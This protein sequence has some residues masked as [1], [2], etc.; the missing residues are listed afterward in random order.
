[1]KISDLKSYKVVSPSPLQS[2][3]N[4]VGSS[5]VSNSSVPPVSG[6]SGG[7]GGG[8]SVNRAATQG[9]TYGASFPATGR[10]TPGQ[11]G[12]K[13]LGNL[14]SSGLNLAK[15]AASFGKTVLGAVK[16]GSQSQNQLLNIF[17]APAAKAGQFLK[18]KAT[19][20]RTET[21]ATQTF[22]VM[23]SSLKERYGSVEN[24]KK[25]A[26]NDPAGFG[27]D[28]LA[29]I[30]GGAGLAG[31]SRM[32]GNAVSKVGGVV[33]KPVSKIASTGARVAEEIA[34][35]AAGVSTGVGK[36]AFKQALRGGEEFT[37]GLRGQMDL[38]TV[39]NEARGGLGKVKQLRSSEYGQA[40]DNLA[41]LN[42]QSLETTPILNKVKGLLKDFNIKQT[43]EGGL[44][45]SRSPLVN[46]KSKI[47]G[48]I[49]VIDE[50]GTTAGDR[51]VRGVDLL[52]RQLRAFREP[53]NPSLN[54]FVD[55]LANSAKEVA[56]GAKGYGDVMG[57][58]GNYSDFIDELERTL[59]LG[60]NSTPDTAISKL[61][62]LLRDNADYKRILAQEFKQTTGKDLLGPIAG[63]AL[64][65][66]TPQGLSKYVAAGAGVASPSIIP[67]LALSSPRVMGEFFRLVGITGRNVGA[68]LSDINNFRVS[69][70]LQKIKNKLPA[71]A[72]EYIK[73]PKAGMSIN[74]VSPMPQM[75]KELRSDLN[76]LMGTGNSSAENARILEVLGDLERPSSQVIRKAQSLVDEFGE[77]ISPTVRRVDVKSSGRSRKVPLKI[78]RE[79]PVP[80]ESN[81]KK[82]NQS[83]PTPL[84]DPKSQRYAGSKS[85]RP[86]IEE[87]K[88][89]VLEI[90]KRF[91]SDAPGNAQAYDRGVTE[92]LDLMP[93]KL[94]KKLQ[95]KID[96]I[97]SAEEV[98]QF[99][100]D[101]MINA[102]DFYNSV[103]RDSVKKIK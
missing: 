52:K 90:E 49:K 69:S 6:P 30:S 5:N 29:V 63:K 77:K 19:G 76:R 48:M 62:S 92:F 32:V 88:R 75:A 70:G 36:E 31:R 15:G 53:S 82:F 60:D 74:D 22:D 95:G 24:L 79:N 7:L 67:F 18:E 21:P 4:M 27:A 8:L 34:T 46:D 11:A 9:D 10:E 28:V 13:A 55:D 57:K 2:K 56:S 98:G 54:K 100:S 41:V 45:L 80:F 61:N 44:D 72:Q 38:T 85:N 50:W 97:E 102:R 1:M 33:T 14:P 78:E 65:R 47:E 12:L 89:L 37:K 51:T 87:A 42:P 83:K 91:P 71:S 94:R 25:T 43:P 16:P 93:P 101:G 99:L 86:D 58:Y 26:I 64:N 39:L 20:V 103:V 40:M 23:S 68:I 3:G 17:A 66:F 35:G 59:S 96:M 73:N 81:G 84:R